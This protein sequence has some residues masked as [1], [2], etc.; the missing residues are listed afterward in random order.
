MRQRAFHDRH[1]RLA[2]L[3]TREV[4][5]RLRAD[6]SLV[7]AARAWLERFAAPDPHQAKAV[8]VWRAVLAL[9]AERIA[10]LLEEDS[11]RGE[12]L[13]DTRPVFSAFDAA[14]MA[15]LVE[16]A[17]GQAGPEC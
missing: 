15:R 3:K 1:A 10:D 2:W 17:R 6:P 7:E 14:T 9:P 16:E 4:A 12:F 11:P 13:R 5:R 8:E